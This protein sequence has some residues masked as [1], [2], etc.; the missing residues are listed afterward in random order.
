[1]GLRPGGDGDR[2]P[3]VLA[4]L[5][6]C[7]GWAG[8]ACAGLL[9][10]PR[11]WFGSGGGLPPGGAPQAAGHGEVRGDSAGGRVGGMGVPAGR[12]RLSSGDGEPAVAGRLPPSPQ[13]R[14]GGG[15]GAAA[16][17]RSAGAVD[18]RGGGGGRSD[19]D[20]AD[21]VPPAVAG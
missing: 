17:V 9:R 2:V 5:G 1:P 8:V 10:P 13:P 3:A 18:G 12:G 15:P 21:A 14:V 19:R 6:G 20:A 4:A 11:G 7:Y 16:G